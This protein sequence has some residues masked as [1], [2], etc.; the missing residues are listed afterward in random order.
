[1]HKIIFILLLLP[2]YAFAEHDENSIISMKNEQISIQR[3]TGIITAVLTFCGNAETNNPSYKS[4]K[5]GFLNYATIIAGSSRGLVSWIIE[6]N[7]GKDIS[8]KFD[9]DMR[10]ITRDYYFK[11]KD[12]IKSVSGKPLSELCNSYKQKINNGEYK[13]VEYS[14]KIFEIDKSKEGNHV[15]IPEENNAYIEFEK[16]KLD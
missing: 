14:K 13:I 5:E 2:I 9:D 12:E 4:Y 16:L 15:T 6:K 11:T 1:M 8:K 7:Q 3:D 10:L